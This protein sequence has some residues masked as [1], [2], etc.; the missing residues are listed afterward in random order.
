VLKKKKRKK[1]TECGITARFEE[2]KKKAQP[3]KKKTHVG[4]NGQSALSEEAS[5]LMYPVKKEQGGFNQKYRKWGN[6]VSVSAVQS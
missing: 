3:L 1:N 4:D 5:R 2:K 6:G